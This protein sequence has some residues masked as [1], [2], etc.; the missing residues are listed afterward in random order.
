LSPTASSMPMNDLTDPIGQAEFVTAMN[1]FTSGVAVVTTRDD[2]RPVG[3]TVAAIA[4]IA[5]DPATVMVSISSTSGTAEVIR[6]TRR[7]AINILD[8]DAAA[9]AGTFASRT[10]D[11]FAGLEIIDDA[12]GSP[13]LPARVAALTCRVVDVIPSGSHWEFRGSVV[14]ADTVDGLPLAYYRGAFAHVTTEADRSLVDSVRVR[15]LSLRSDS[16]H[17]LDPDELAWDFDASRGTVLRALSGLKAEGLVERVGGVHR[18]TALPDTVVDQI[19]QAKL[20]IE[21]GAAVQVIGRVTDEDLEALRALLQPIRAAAPGGSAESIED[22]VVALNRF[23]ERFVGLAGSQP[24]VR[25]Y[26]SLGLPGVDRRSITAAIFANIPPTGGFEEVVD[27]LQRGNLTAVLDAL[28]SDRRTPA[29]VRRAAR[30]Q[31]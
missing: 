16:A 24:L 8:E 23:G 10:A 9:V 12:L 15:V 29:F 31:R 26:R 22:L 19:Y 18:V 3:V 14:C 2:G 20:A 11:R 4:P 27:G 1:L 21:I 17:V 5:S 25:A 7:F 13:L 30:E 6:R 28:R